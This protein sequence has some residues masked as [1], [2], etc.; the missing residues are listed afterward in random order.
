M[1][2]RRF[3]NVNTTAQEIIMDFLVKNTE[4]TTEDWKQLIELHPEQAGDI[5]DA[6]LLR[7]GT[8]RLVEADAEAPVNKAA[9]EATVSEAINVLHTTPS[10]QLVVLEEK[11]AA[12]RGAA[13]R[14]LAAEVGLGSEVALLNSILAGTVV[15]P[16]RVMLRLTKVLDTSVAA[17][18]EFFGRVF[19][20][21]EVPA[22]KAVAGKPRVI[23][24]PTSWEDAVKSLS[25][26]S[27]RTREL[28]SLDE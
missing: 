16:R 22:F 28:L 25:L 14:K 15:A 1:M 9:Y 7:Q 13:A 17:L 11:V 18:T 10:P 19:E 8:Q 3:E 5:A 24:K 2:K 23:D 4:P 20:S 26:S 12:V 6:A 27:E 21:R